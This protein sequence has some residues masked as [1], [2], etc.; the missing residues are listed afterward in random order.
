MRHVAVNIVSI[1]QEVNDVHIEDQKSQ[2]STTAIVPGDVKII[3]ENH[4]KRPKK[5]K[6]PD[7]N[8]LGGKNYPFEGKC[9][10]I[11]IF[12]CKICSYETHDKYNHQAHMV[13]VHNTDASKVLNCHICGYTTTR[14]SNMYKHIRSTHEKS[15]KHECKDCGKIYNRRQAM[16]IH[17][18]I[19]H[20]GLKISCNI[21]GAEFG[22]KV[23]LAKH[24]KVHPL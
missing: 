10:K 7:C 16:I 20:L 12:K 2:N 13:G 3:D 4:A 21:C 5:E 9:K 11:Q 18:R 23:H 1:N 14:K 22:Q 6:N 24:M 15:E 17:F 8:C 19:K